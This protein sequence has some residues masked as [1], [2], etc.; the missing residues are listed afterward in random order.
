MYSFTNYLKNIKLF[1]KYQ[2]KVIIYKLLLLFISFIFYGLI[3]FSFPDREF[4]GISLFQ[5]EIRQ[6]AVQDYLKSRNKKYQEINSDEL[7]NIY[8]KIEGTGAFDVQ[9]P[10]RETL[11]NRFYFA[12]VTGTTLG[13]GDIYPVSFKVKS[14]TILQLF[15]SLCILFY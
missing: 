6:K 10:L 15:T 13:Y 12:I 14:V 9:L 1:K 11:F 8:T 2:F 4:G 5:N 7:K 3:Y